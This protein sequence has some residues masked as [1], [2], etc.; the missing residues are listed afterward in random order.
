MRGGQEKMKLRIGEK[1][2]LVR[3]LQNRLWELGYNP[4]PIDG[5]FCRETRKAISRFQ[6]DKSFE[7]DGMVGPL[8]LDALGLKTELHAPKPNRKTRRGIFTPNKGK[9]II[10][11]R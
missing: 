11:R 4:G 8:T 1:G 6:K 7:A 9:E 10:S 5:I 2:D 3:N